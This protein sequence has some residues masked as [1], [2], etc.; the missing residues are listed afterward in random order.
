MGGARR[1]GDE[2][3]LTLRLSV[4]VVWL[5]GLGL[6]SPAEAQVPALQTPS[7]SE[8]AAP[9]AESRPSEDRIVARRAELRAAMDELR[10]QVAETAEAPEEASPERRELE[11]LDRL[12][13]LQLAELRRAAELSEE[14]EPPDLLTRFG[15]PPPYSI[16]ELDLLLDEL[17][18][19]SAAR[20]VSAATLQ[21]ADRA[22]E[23]ALQRRAEIEPADGWLGESSPGP[24]EPVLA[25]EAALEQVRLRRL[26]QD[27]AQSD[28][29]LRL[30]RERRLEAQ[31]R[32]L[33]EQLQPAAS[34]LEAALAALATRADPLE[35]RLEA[36]RARLAGAEE[37]ASAVK[38]RVDL[39][40][41]PGPGLLAEAEAARLEVDAARERIDLLVR[42]REQIEQLEEAWRLRFR[43]L[44]GD[45]SVREMT[46]TAKEVAG[47]L[48]ELDRER[49]L[50]EARLKERRLTLGVLRDQRAGES[51]D[52]GTRRWL[53]R[54]EERLE[55]V[56]TLHER[57]LEE[58]ASARRLLSR[59][60]DE[61]EARV[62][63]INVR[64]RLALAWERLNG[65]WNLQLTSTD[66]EPITVGKLVQML[67][68][69]GVGYLISKILSRRLGQSV[70]PRFGLARGAVVAFQTLAYYGLLA[71]FF[72]WA[73]RVVNIPLTVF[74]VVGGV[75]AIG[76]GFG[77]QNIMN[78]FI[79]GLIILAEHPIKVGD[80]I[81]IDGI[82]GQVE[83]IGPRS[84][85]IRAGDNTHVIVPNSTFLEK[86]VLN[87]TVSDDVIRTWV[88]VGVAYG[89]PVEQV[90]EDLMRAA[91]EEPGVLDQPEPEVLFMDFGDN[92]LAFRVYFWVQ[93]KRPLDRYRVQS[94]LRFRI[95]RVFGEAGIVIAFPQ[96]DVHLDSLSPLEVRVVAGGEK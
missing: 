74:T 92:A 42:Q 89:S 68:L 33:R 78:N 93:V 85:R 80:L 28:H 38:D 51:V 3:I 47:Q 44:A 2:T 66:G 6:V 58:L 43:V 37:R 40:R 96:R 22:L 36:A 70:L 26:Q 46:A 61:L 18:A 27:T 29:E 83:R 54:Q 56:V 45:A 19:A 13:D 81:D 65:V 52:P 73:L 87:W 69:L 90:A 24:S 12:L 49:Q 79:S 59:L 63:T 94:R 5:L 72:L 55:E 39:A 25:V 82:F 15:H 53:A 14:A 67:L 21:Q 57:E 91:S 48:A 16:V 30:A 9:D 60:G 23:G 1:S 84:S 7:E 8:P 50:I 95:D 17:E 75:L 32:Q 4:I 34:D 62:G 77:S 76:I 86:N 88:D 71:V 11:R 31:V 20:R 10:G 41:A 35:E 64:E